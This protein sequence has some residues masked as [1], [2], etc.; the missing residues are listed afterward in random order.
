M[1]FEVFKFLV[2]IIKSVKLKFNSLVREYNPLSGIINE[3]MYL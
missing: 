2:V 3:K 1:S